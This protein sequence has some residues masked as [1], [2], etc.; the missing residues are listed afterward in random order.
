MNILKNET[1]SFYP[2]RLYKSKEISCI[3][4]YSRRCY[5]KSVRLY[6]ANGWHQWQLYQ[7]QVCH[8]V[9]EGILNTGA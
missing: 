1:V 5:T 4:I 3:N 2:I 7:T 8:Y 6:R 9:T